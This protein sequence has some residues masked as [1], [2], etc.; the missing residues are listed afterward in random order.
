MSDRHAAAGAVRRASVRERE[1]AVEERLRALAAD[2][3]GD[4]APGFRAAT[5]ARVVAMAAVRTPEPVPARSRRPARVRRPRPAAAVAGVAVAVTGLGAVVALSG[6]AQ[7]GDVLYGV[8]RGTEQTRLALAGDERGLTLLGFATTRLAE[9]DA[10]VGSTPGAPPADLV[11]DTLTAMDAQT[12]EGAA[13]VLTR[14]A[15]TRDAAPLT[16][17]DDWTD[18]Q[19][20]GLAELQRALPADAGA[21]GSLDL[22]SEVG[23]RAAGLREALACPVGPVTAGAD[24]LGPLPVPCDDA[25][26][27]PGAS[28]PAPAPAG[29]RDPAS[30]VG[31]P[32]AA[33]TSPVPGS[34]SGGGAGTSGSPAAPT[35]DSPSG[36]APPTGS[37]APTAPP[38]G[39]A[40]RSA[41]PQLPVPQFPVPRL[42]LPELPLPPLPLP[43]AGPAP[44][45]PAVPGSSS[46]SLLDTPLPVCVRPLVC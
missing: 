23:A 43:G 27:P 21:A 34:G 26:A 16:V 24:E 20:S 17:L 44:S 3:D 19:R 33:P 42:P 37:S 13:L 4:P 45:D 36:V 30:P 22:V 46:G 35:A 10:L 14:A 29:G 31:P 32:P 15:D 25:P 39:P 11:R 8:K 5:R 41:V 9:L 40:G 1:A 28:T 6:S 7:P 38:P 18:E 12:T 2:L